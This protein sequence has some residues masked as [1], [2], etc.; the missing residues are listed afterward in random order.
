MSLLNVRLSWRA[1]W[2]SGADRQTANHSRLQPFSSVASQGLGNHF[3]RQRHSLQRLPALRPRR[4]GQLRT[5]LQCFK[6]DR[7]QRAGLWSAAFGA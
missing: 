6:A 1:G 7:T 3:G 5:D 4:G 2:R